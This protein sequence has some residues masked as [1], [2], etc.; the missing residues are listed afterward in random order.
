MQSKVDGF[1]EFDEFRLDGKEQGFSPA[2]RSLCPDG[3]AFEPCPCWWKRGHS[4]PKTSLCGGVP[5]SLVEE[6]NLTQ[7]SSYAESVG[8]DSRSGVHRDRAG[9]VTDLWRT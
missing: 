9:E 3:K 7:T 2:S 4:L 5:D 1:Y 6:A 8:A